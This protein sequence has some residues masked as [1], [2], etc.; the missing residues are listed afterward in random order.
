MSKEV[1]L[2]S[3]NTVVIKDPKTL[4]VKDRDKVFEAMDSEAVNFKTA[5]NL[6]KTTL[7]VLIESWSF[8][9]ILPS[10]K[11]ETL[12]ELDLSDY[13]ELAKEAEAAQKI[14]FPKFNTDGGKN[15]P[16]DK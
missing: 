1:K 3:G 9:L 10:V 12:G 15:S 8:D 2:P 14:L 6:I 5:I 16:K 11:I 7:A 13:D 4:K